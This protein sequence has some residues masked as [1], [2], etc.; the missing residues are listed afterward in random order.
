MGETRDPGILNDLVLDL[1]VAVKT[2]N[3]LKRQIQRD[4]ALDMV[5]VDVVTDICESIIGLEDYDDE[6]DDWLDAEG[7]TFVD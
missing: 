3:S 7:E 5:V 1:K 2:L 6:V 4:G